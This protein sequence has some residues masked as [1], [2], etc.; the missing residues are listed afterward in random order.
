LIEWPLDEK[1]GFYGSVQRIVIELKILRSSLETL[2]PSALEQTADYADKSK[3]DE[4]HLL[5]FNRDKN[6]PWDEKI[7][8]RRESNKTREIWIWGC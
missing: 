8:Q 1:K 2:L 7:W 6:T 4:A 5:V 3:A